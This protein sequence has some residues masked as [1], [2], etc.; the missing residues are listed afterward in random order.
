VSSLNPRDA[1]L[2][3]PGVDTAVCPGMTCR[4]GRCASTCTETAELAGL[5]NWSA[6]RLDLGRMQAYPATFT[7]RTACDTDQVVTVTPGFCCLNKLI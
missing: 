5:G 7:L 4:S 1:A 6:E 2:P 3:R